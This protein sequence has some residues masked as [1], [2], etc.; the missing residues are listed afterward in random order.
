MK[1]DNLKLCTFIIIGNYEKYKWIIFK[2]LL[3]YHKT[4]PQLRVKL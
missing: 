2:I 1:K 3:S 4:F